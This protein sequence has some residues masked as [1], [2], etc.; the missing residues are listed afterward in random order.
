VA[1]S[2]LG[3]Q[4]FVACNKVHLSPSWLAI[5]LRGQAKKIHLVLYAKGDLRG[6]PATKRTPLMQSSE[7]LGD[8]FVTENQNT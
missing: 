4:A 6:A 8:R 3:L 2:S 5:D 7:R 1:S